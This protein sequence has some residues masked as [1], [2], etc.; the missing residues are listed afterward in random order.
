MRIDFLGRSLQSALLWVGNIRSLLN[1]SLKRE[2]LVMVSV[3]L[4]NEL[5]RED[6]TDTIAKINRVGMNEVI[7]RE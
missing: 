3:L 1:L 6:P 7:Q 5:Y 2:R 4:P